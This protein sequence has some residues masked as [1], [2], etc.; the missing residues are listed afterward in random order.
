MKTKL[1]GFLSGIIMATLMLVVSYTAEAQVITGP[2]VTDAIINSVSQDQNLLEVRASNP[3]PARF[4]NTRFI[5]DNANKNAQLA[6]LLTAI[7][8][9]KS[10][11][12]T[13][14]SGNPAPNPHIISRVELIN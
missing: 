9:N 13:F 4:Q 11:R 2:F 1:K 12:I 5:I 3:D 7:S 6:V 8:T 10:V 14:T